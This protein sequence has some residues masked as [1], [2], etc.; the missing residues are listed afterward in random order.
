MNSNRGVIT[1][2]LFVAP[3]L[4][5]GLAGPRPATAQLAVDRSSRYE[6]VTVPRST[7]FEATLNQELSTK[8]NRAGDRFTATLDRPV[9]DG[10]LVLIPAG[11]TIH[12]KVTAAGKSRD[13]GQKELRVV[14][15]SISVRGRTYPV[16]AT[17]TETRA[18]TKR[19][20]VG[21]TALKIGI[22]TAA[23][24]IL[25]RVIGGDSEGT[26]IG[27]AVGAVVGTAVA[28]GTH[29]SEAILDQG[30]VLRFRLDEPL[31]ID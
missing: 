4:A 13:S 20:S 31:Y 16:A 14:V 21:E 26:L 23:G 24:A 2:S 7:E 19:T 3:L 8:R 6:T 17:I 27:A 28:I 18:R 12:G 5:A 15:T 30:S 9:T 29:G 11:A 1:V 25:G 10:R 22:G